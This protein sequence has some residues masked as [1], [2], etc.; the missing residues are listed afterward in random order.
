MMGHDGFGR[1]GEFNGEYGGFE[2]WKRVGEDN[3]SRWR[4]Q[5][6]H[7]SIRAD[8]TKFSFK[9]FLGLIKMTEPNYLLL[10][11]G[12]IF[13]VISSSV[14]VYVPKLASSLVNN[15]QRE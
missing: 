12:M 13:L 7:D 5:N 14:Q 15:F 3:G 6:S 1:F 10:G 8:K 4:R 11:I 9:E 2:G